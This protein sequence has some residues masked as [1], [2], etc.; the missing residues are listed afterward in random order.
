MKVSSLKEYY[1]IKGWLYQSSNFGPAGIW[2]RDPCIC[3]VCYFKWLTRG[4]GGSL[5]PCESVTHAGGPGSNNGV[6]QLRRLVTL[7]PLKLQQYT[8]HFWKPLIFFYLDKRGQGHSYILNTQKAFVKI[9]G[10]TIVSLLAGY[11]SIWLSQ[12]FL[13]CPWIPC[14]CPKLSLTDILSINKYTQPNGDIPR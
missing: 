5:L 10:F 1:L 11:I 12:E 2:A 13:S 14:L 7:K 3:H 8:L 6:T 9:P 4:S